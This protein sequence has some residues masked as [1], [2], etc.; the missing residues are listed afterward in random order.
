MKFYSYTNI[1]IDNLLLTNAVK[2]FHL[3]QLRNSSVLFNNLQGISK[4]KRND[5]T[6]FKIKLNS[7]Y[8]GM[9]KNHH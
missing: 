6:Q 4:I 3:L 5:L 2:F 7:S 8:R 9:R 1:T